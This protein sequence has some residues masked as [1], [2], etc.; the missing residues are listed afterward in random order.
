MTTHSEMLGSHV[1]CVGGVGRS[2]DGRYHGIK[3]ILKELIYF[4]WSSRWKRNVLP[5]CVKLLHTKVSIIFCG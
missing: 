3:L 5:N 1:L 4:S 2:R